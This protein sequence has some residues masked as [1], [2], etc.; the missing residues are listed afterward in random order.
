M[1]PTSNLKTSLDLKEIITRCVKESEDAG[2]ITNIT[3]LNGKV[4]KGLINED[5][6][7]DHVAKTVI[8]EL[9]ELEIIRKLAPMF[10]MFRSIERDMEFIENRQVAEQNIAN[11]R[12]NK[13]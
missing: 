13:S 10:R 3:E 11:L 4:I 12:I 8:G 5:A 7:C 1:L 2:H 9:H 6:F